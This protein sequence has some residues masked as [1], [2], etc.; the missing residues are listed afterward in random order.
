MRNVI[1]DKDIRQTAKLANV[2]QVIMALGEGYDTVFNMNAVSGGLAQR[3]Q[4]ARAHDHNQLRHPCWVI[5]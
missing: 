4:I 5:A 2:H 1:T 3:V